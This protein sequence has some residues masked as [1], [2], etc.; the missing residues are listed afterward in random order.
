MVEVKKLKEEDLPKV[1]KLSINIFK[2]S[3]NEIN[4]FHNTQKWTENYS[5]DSLLLGAFF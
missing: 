3:E 2:P 4:K 1:V 5:K